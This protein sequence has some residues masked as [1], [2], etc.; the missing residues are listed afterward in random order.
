MKKDLLFPNFSDPMTIA[1]LLCD[2][3]QLRATDSRSAVLCSLERWLR[4]RGALSGDYEKLSVFARQLDNDLGSLPR[5]VFEAALFLYVRASNPDAA[6]N[7]YPT[8][9]R[10]LTLVQL[11]R[12]VL[13]W[14]ST[15]KSVPSTRKRA[16][17][18][19]KAAQKPRAAKAK[20]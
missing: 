1:M 6:P 8:Q 19:R 16:Q 4:T 5:Q 14:V 2:S 11:A 18:K 9:L 13:S 17:V 15:V 10:G 20:R 7:L 12:Y 3:A